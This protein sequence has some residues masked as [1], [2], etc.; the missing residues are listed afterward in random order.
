MPENSS[1]GNKFN[2][3]AAAIR[4]LAKLLDETGLTEIEVAEGERLLR[5]NKGGIAAGH[6]FAAAPVN[7]RDV[8]PSDPAAIKAPATPAAVTADTPGAVTSP[9][10][11]TAYMAAEPGAP[12]FVSKGATVKE[13]DTLMIIEAMKVMNPIK[14]PKSGV[15][16]Q[17]LVENGKPIEFGEVL[18]VVE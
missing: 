15:V 5:V 11:G 9:M 12:A 6:P 2:I 7:V 3:D 16:S 13:G 14:A 17:I 4:Q 8:M 10:V 1:K 18:M